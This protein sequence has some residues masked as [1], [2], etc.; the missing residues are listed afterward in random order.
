MIVRL[1]PTV[2]GDG[3]DIGNGAGDSFGEDRD[4]RLRCH[5]FEASRCRSCT[6]IETP[7]ARQ[8]L[9]K[10]QRCRELLPSVPASAWLPSFS[11]GDRG[12][13]NRVKLVVGGVPGH[14]T[15]GILGPDGR[16]VDLRECAIQAPA[17][18]AVIPAIASFLDSTGLAPYDVPAR[19]GELK[20]VHVTAA[21]PSHGSGAAEVSELMLRFVGRTQL[22]LDII[23]ARLDALRAAVPNAVV[24]SVNL[25]PEHKAALEGEREEMLL[26][27]S[28]PM[29]LGF[30]ERPLTLH[31]M[32]QSFF[33][34]NT[35]VAR[36]LYA[37]V[38]EWVLRVRP[39]SLWDLYCGVGGFALHC[40]AALAAGSGGAAH[41][42]A[43]AE[44]A[45]TPDC[46]VLGVELSE[47]AID[48]AR[49]SSREANL[50]AEFLAADATRV[51]VTAAPENLPELLIVNPPRR[52]IGAELSSWIEGS[53]IAHLVYSSCNPE[54]LA[55]D[56]AAMPSYEV[57]QGRVFDM[58]PHTSHLEVA[59]L[60]ERVR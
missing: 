48:S 55:R 2:R 52:G 17:I 4:G 35:A 11:G 40:A 14:V 45:G 3:R 24:I 60:L 58:F 41:A 36:K 12:F 1:P 20:F 30:D 10:E 9:D 32:P 34:T 7:Y 47:A 37:Q 50:A 44:G 23:R 43:H 57:R 51:A 25:L 54:S 42:A 29:R 16:G 31:L 27:S 59:V 26:G 13:R 39:A 28:L 18:A 49:R 53:G 5:Y 21:P 38:A 56:L 46:H 19:R 15:L 8:L 6:L 33:Q 22:T